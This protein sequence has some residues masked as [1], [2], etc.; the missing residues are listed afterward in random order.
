MSL[1]RM[2]SYEKSLVC[3][4][5]DC[6]KNNITPNAMVILLKLAIRSSLF[7]QSRMRLLSRQRVNAQPGKNCSLTT[8]RQFRKNTNRIIRAVRASRRR[9]RP[10]WN[11]RRE[12][13]V[14]LELGVRQVILLEPPIRLAQVVMRHCVLWL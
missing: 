12:P 14:Q 6:A 5:G 3:A 2:D 4:S 9:A 7:D 1:S 11:S 8:V 10:R 13:L